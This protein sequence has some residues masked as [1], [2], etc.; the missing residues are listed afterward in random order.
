[1]QP[2][3]VL[4]IRR[5]RSQ[6]IG[7][8]THRSREA[9][10]NDDDQERQCREQD[11]KWLQRPQRKLRGAPFT[12]GHRLRDLDHAFACFNAEDAPAAIAGLDR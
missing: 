8:L 12:H 11:C 6:C 9:P 10:H 1:M 2:A 5:A 7:K 3:P 4:F